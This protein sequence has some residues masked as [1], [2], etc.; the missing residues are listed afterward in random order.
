MIDVNDAG[1]RRNTQDNALQHAHQVIVRAVIG[2]QRDDRI[3]HFSELS[4][5][6]FP[7]RYSVAR[8]GA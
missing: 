5:F 1:V 7:R 3:R 8:S 4:P 2:R 6:N